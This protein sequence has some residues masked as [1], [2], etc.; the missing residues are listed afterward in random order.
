M[1]TKITSENRSKYLELFEKAS[2]FLATHNEALEEVPIGSQNALLKAV[3]VSSL[4]NFSYAPNT[5]YFKH[6]L[7]DA[8]TEYEYIKDTTPA[9]GTEEHLAIIESHKPYYDFGITSLSEYFSYITYLTKYEYR[10]ESAG[11]SVTKFS[12][13]PLDEDLFEINADSRVVTVPADTFAKYG[14]SV[15]GDEIAEIVYFKINRFYDAQDFADPDIK[16]I[17]QWKSAAKDEEGK[18]KEGISVPW[19]VDYD[20]YPGYVVV[21]WPISSGVTEKAGTVELSVRFIKWDRTSDTLSYSFATQPV[22]VVIKNSLDFDLSKYISEGRW[23]T[24]ITDNTNLI[25]SRWKDTQY[26]DPNNQA[27]V[28]NILLDLPEVMTL[29]VNNND[30][31]FKSKATKAYIQ[32]VTPDQ[33]GRI[34]YVWKKYDLVTNRLSDIDFRIVYRPIETPVEYNNTKA[35]YIKEDEGI[36]AYTAYIEEDLEEK[37]ALTKP[38]PEEPDNGW[39]QFYEQV[40]EADIDSEGQ[41]EVI[42]TNRVGRSTATAE[43]TKMFIYKPATPVITNENN[44]E[45]N[46]ILDPNVDDYKATLQIIAS[47]PDEGDLTYQWFRVAPGRHDETATA[48]ED[49]EGLYEGAQTDT[50]IIT[51]ADTETDAGGA[52][53]DGK[54]YCKVTNHLNKV[55]DPTITTADT[56]ETRMETT[57]RVSHPAVPLIVRFVDNAIQDMRKSDAA[58][59]GITFAVSYPTNN[60]AGSSQAMQENWF[61]DE[62]PITYQWYQYAQEDGSDLATD[63]QAAYDQ[64][65]GL[66]DHVYRDPAHPENVRGD[67]LIEGANSITYRPSD[68]GYYYL[69]VTHHYNGTTAV[70]YSPFFTINNA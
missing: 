46:V 5:Y 16:P 60:T 2:T 54:Y 31:G 25:N 43:S 52:V 58:A 38:L 32:A 62:T 66:N 56:K 34:T 1:I 59:Q 19:T 40:S 36:E 61:A 39:I 51:G 18:N 48:L 28:P 24:N 50:L 22:E 9:D 26:N 4:D 21:G 41:Y 12:F 57:I 6:V 10:E 20:M 42:V 11:R 45:T 17:I 33:G 37:L 7:N 67:I 8:G 30:N 14:V 15:Q 64:A 47:T 63:L 13:L 70:S 68:A 23:N 49:T 65:Y 69:E 53:G 29:A 27:N 55:N 3:E 35:Y 44:D